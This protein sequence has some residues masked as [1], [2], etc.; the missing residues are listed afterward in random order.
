MNFNRR[1]AA[2][3]YYVSPAYRSLFIIVPGT[4]SPEA[5]TRLRLPHNVACGFPALRSS[6]SDSQHSNGLKFP[7]GNR[8]PWLLQR[9]TCFDPMKDRPRERAFTAAATKHLIPVT[10][11]DPI[12]S[13][14]VYRIILA[15]SACQTLPRKTG[16]LADLPGTVMLDAVYRPRGAGRHSSLSHLPFCLRLLS[17][18]RH[19]PNSSHQGYVPDSGHTPFTSLNLHITLNERGDTLPGGLINPTREGLCFRISLSTFNQSQVQTITISLS[20]IF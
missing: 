14:Q 18:D 11:N 8:K 20:Q 10:F 7:I 2:R 1:L 5:V 4:G 16:N 6:E 3:G 19:F 15:L 12:H 13:L 9:K 17:R